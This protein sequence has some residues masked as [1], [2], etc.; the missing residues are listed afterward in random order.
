MKAEDGRF[1]A[2]ILGSGA[3]E[4]AADLADKC[5]LHP[6]LAGGVQELAHLTVHVAKAGRCAENDRS[7][8]GRCI[9]H[10]NWDMGHALL[11]FQSSHHPQYLIGQR[12]RYALDDRQQLYDLAWLHIFVKFGRKSTIYRDKIKALQEQGLWCNRY[13]LK[14]E[15]L[16][17]IVYNVL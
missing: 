17:V 1:L 11:G 3:G 13:G 5:T 14:D 16:A 15:V 12:F 2:V 7:G 6:E 9:H 4:N 10:S 8:Y